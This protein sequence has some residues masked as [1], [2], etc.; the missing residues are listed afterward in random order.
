MNKTYFICCFVCSFSFVLCFHSYYVQL[1]D[2]IKSSFLKFLSLQV[3]D[4]FFELIL[5]VAWHFSDIFV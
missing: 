4:S 1:A 2:T 5:C 3:N